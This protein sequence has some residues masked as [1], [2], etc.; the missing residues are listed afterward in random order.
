MP[1]QKKKN[2]F[3]GSNTFT[4]F[5]KSCDIARSK[6]KTQSLIQIILF[7]SKKKKKSQTLQKGHI[8]RSAHLCHGALRPEQQSK[9]GRR[10]GEQGR[11]AA[12]PPFLPEEQ[13]LIQTVDSELKAQRVWNTQT[14]VGT[15]KTCCSEEHQETL[16]IQGYKQQYLYGKIRTRLKGIKGVKQ[17]KMCH[18]GESEVKNVGCQFS[19]KLT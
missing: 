1:S 16:I 15:F 5:K 19:S 6:I 12:A 3:Y 9:A 17:Q 2:F 8:S 7:K 11:G 4:L 18:V 13:E 14:K 10:K